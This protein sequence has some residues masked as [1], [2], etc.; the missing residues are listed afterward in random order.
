MTPASPGRRPTTDVAA[1][2]A[3][4][5]A[6]FFDH[7]SATRNDIFRRKP[8]LDYE[9][10]TR[11]AAVLRALHAGNGE[12]ILDIGCGNARDILPLLRTGARVT[13]IDLSEGMIQEAKHELSAAGR[14]D[15]TVAVGDATRLEFA[16]EAFDK[17]LCSEVIEHIPDAELA[18]SE[19]H[20]VL[21]PG[22]C[23]V[24][25]TPNRRSWYGFDRYVIWMRLLRRRW[26]HP[27]DNWR[28]I[29]DLRALL[30][31]HGF[32]VMTSVTVCYLPGFLLTYFLP[33]RLQDLVVSCV[34]R[35]APL[36]S[37]LAPR[38][39]YLLVVTAV[40]EPAAPASSIVQPLPARST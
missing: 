38:N 18:V 33:R 32:R 3:S 7:M 22:G 15:V 40:K 13:G 35:A 39:G 23:L 21:K 24:V 34:R 10:A 28:T 2:R 8:I 31:R 11:S 20:R 19:M 5:I 25:S 6:L 37:R 4:S 30:E 17:I 14:P 9:Q 29:A 26:D 12:R 16:A 36:A 1:D 27:F